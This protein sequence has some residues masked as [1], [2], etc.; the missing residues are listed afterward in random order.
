MEIT[1]SNQ[2][3]E[4]SGSPVRPGNHALRHPYLVSL[5][6]GFVL[7]VLFD[8]IPHLIHVE[9]IDKAMLRLNGTALSALSSLRPGDLAKNFYGRIHGS[10]YSLRVWRWSAPFNL[11]EVKLEEL[12]QHYPSWDPDA[13]DPPFSPLYPTM[14]EMA[15]MESA[16]GIDWPPI[17]NFSLGI[18][19]AT[20][21]TLR[22]TITNGWANF[23][24]GLLATLAA[25]GLY[26]EI[27]RRK[28]ISLG[29]WFLLPAVASFCA[30]VLWGVACG[31]TW[32]LGEVLK[33]P[34]VSAL[35]ILAPAILT[36]ISHTAED[37]LAYI[38]RSHH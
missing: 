35:G 20:I 14:R 30:W 32:F 12:R 19:D 7:T 16:K 6:I 29:G 31:S 34:D 3:D 22:R 24:L 33:A 21:D 8:L 26:C 13:S 2:V 5:A 25:I 17:I 9:E 38:R 10:R 15:F 28:E 4:T 11:T 27:S 36:A 23:L 1:P 37:L 18:P